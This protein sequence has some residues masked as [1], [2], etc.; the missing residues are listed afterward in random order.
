MSQELG[1][2]ERPTADRFQGK[3]KLL[4]VPLLYG[5]PNVSEEGIEILQRYWE[6]VQSQLSSLESSLGGLSHIYHESLVIGGSEG[7]QQ[8]ELVDQRSHGFVSAKCASGAAL[9][10]TEDTETFLET[11]DLQRCLM[12]PLISEK[13]GRTLQEWL[14]ESNKARYEKIGN[15]IDETLGED[16]VGLLMISE[17]H[18]V[19]FATDIEVFYISPPALADFQTWLQQWVAQQQ[20]APAEPSDDEE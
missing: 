7:L 13:V 3:R 4:L 12:V 16:E 11:L 19:Q 18:Q 5:P 2:L 15:Q 9:E 6:Q 17:R 8:L 1:R 10:A 14:M 20:A